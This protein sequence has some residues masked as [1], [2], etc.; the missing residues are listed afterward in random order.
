MIVQKQ[1]TLREFYTQHLA[2]IK[3]LSDNCLWD[4]EF[5]SASGALELLNGVCKS[6]G[7]TVQVFAL[8]EQEKLIAAFPYAVQ[9]NRWLLPIKAYIMWWDV[10]IANNTPLI[11]KNYH[12]IAF[13]HIGQFLQKNGGI[14]LIHT[15]PDKQF[16]KAIDKKYVDIKLTYNHSK[17]TYKI[18]INH[19]NTTGSVKLIWANSIEIL[20]LKIRAI[21]S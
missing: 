10:E 6:D 1:L 5:Y 19:S 12:D 7:E 2:D 4:N 14:F 16:I 21:L 9:N 11:D 20:R 15:C 17:N 3:S 13:L 18:F 8:F